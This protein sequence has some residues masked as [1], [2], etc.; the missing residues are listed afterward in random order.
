VEQAADTLQRRDPLGADADPEEIL[1]HLR[2]VPPPQPPSFHVQRQDPRNAPQNYP[3]PVNAFPEPVP[4]VPQPRLQPAPP[5]DQVTM[6]MQVIATARAVSTI[7]ASRI[8][9][10]LALLCA[11]A[12]WGVTIADPLQ[13]RIISASI[14]SAV[15]L[16]PL[17]IL[18]LRK[19]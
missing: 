4:Q 19:G 12:L 8:L 9:L 17:I 18:A 14:F 5:R 3:S 2:A 13:N 1:R 15:V 16:W 10:L 7:M 6:A 11:S